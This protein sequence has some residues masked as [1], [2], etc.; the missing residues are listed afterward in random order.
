MKSKKALVT[1]VALL[2]IFTFAL[3]NPGGASAHCDTMDG[4]V[5]QTAKEALQTGNINPVLAWIEE[6]DEAEVR[7][8]FD[9]ALRERA[10]DGA[11]EEAAD[12]AF[13]ETV[14]RLHRAS[15]GEE[16]TGLKPAGTDLGPVVPNADKALAGGSADALVAQVTGAVEEGI[17][18][19]FNDVMAKK[20]YD[21]NDVQAGREYVDSYVKYMHFAEVI[22]EAS[23]HGPEAAH[24]EGAA[25]T[26]Q[27]GAVSAATHV[28]SD[29]AA[30]T[31]H[32]NASAPQAMLPAT[33][34]AEGPDY[35]LSLVGGIALVALGA[36]AIWRPVRKSR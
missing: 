31:E 30:E 21:K 1:I 9:K 3:L 10:A 25:H 12:T 22:Y 29:A 32:T 19:R 8:A 26:E 18:T 24:A 16:F 17:Q 36:F 13:F 20:N 34:S 5:V 11:T 2:S 7:A 15:E 6:K 33:G 28:E 4:P 35:L 27:T 14:V 23:M